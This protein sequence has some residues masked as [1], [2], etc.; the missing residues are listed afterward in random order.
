MSDNLSPLSN[1]KSALLESWIWSEYSKQ[2]A[3]IMFPHSMQPP[4]GIPHY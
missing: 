1:S 3:D 4:V 2:D